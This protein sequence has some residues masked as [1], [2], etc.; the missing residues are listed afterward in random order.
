MNEHEIN[1]RSQKAFDKMKSTKIA[2]CGVGALG[3]NLVN[4]LVRQGFEKITIIDMDRVEQKN[5]ATQVYGM[6]DVGQM[7]VN[8]LK[9]LVYQINKKVLSV[10]DKE[11]NDSNFKK[12]LDDHDLIVDV[13]DNWPSRKLTNQAGFL[14]RIPVVHA[15]MS[16]SG[17]AEIK[18]NDHYKIPE[19]EKEQK[20]ICDYPLAANLVHITASILAEV[21]TQFAIHF[22]MNNKEITLRDIRVH[23]T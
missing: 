6:K 9:G 4:N 11:L 12:V 20:D 10:F 15:G 23:T 5:I 16:D 17:F 22:E 14:L 2:V 21:I 7:K 8:A 18:W 3:S 19:I 1:Y 13:F